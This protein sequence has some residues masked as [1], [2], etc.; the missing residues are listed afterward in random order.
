MTVRW[1]GF[2]CLIWLLIALLLGELYGSVVAALGQS[3]VIGSAMV[4]TLLALFVLG[5]FLTCRRYS[6]FLL[7]KKSVRWVIFATLPAIGA[8]GLSLSTFLMDGL[9]FNSQSLSSQWWIFLL[10]VP[11]VE[12]L[13]F[14]L[15]L[16][17]GLRRVSSPLVA[18]Y[19]SSLVFGLMHGGFRLESLLMGAIVIPLG[20]VL[21]AWFCEYI[22]TRTNSILL[23]VLFHA[24][25][26]GSALIF[27]AFD[28]RWLDWLGFLYISN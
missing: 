7:K 11:I 26:N 14:R 27:Q 22:F 5:Y 28:P 12:E 23:C 9:E 6:V 15:G 24:S 2:Q 18:A 10:W 19:G 16:S 21:M 4:S 17:S 20:S 8:L 1:I 25:C 13:A 3:P